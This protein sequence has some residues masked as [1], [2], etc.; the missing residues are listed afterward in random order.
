MVLQTSRARDTDTVSY[1]SDTDND[2]AAHNSNV[3]AVNSVV[4]ADVDIH[5]VEVD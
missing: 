1:S 5:E 2:T 3:T 4:D